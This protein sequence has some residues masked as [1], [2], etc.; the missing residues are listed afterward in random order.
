MFTNDHF[1]F[2]HATPSLN[3]LTTLSSKWDHIF[4]LWIVKCRSQWQVLL[5]T[6]LKFLM[7]SP[8]PC[9]NGVEIITSKTKG[10]HAQK[11]KEYKVERNRAKEWL[12]NEIFFCMY[13]D[14]LL[15]WN[16]L[17]LCWASTVWVYLILIFT[18]QPSV[19]KAYE[20]DF[21]GHVNSV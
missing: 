3:F 15:W 8:V 16:K 12:L 9:Q 13:T 14:I 11:M 21:C 20:C 7:F 4:N 1:L 5:N 10:A 19:N 6:P 17:V 2:S 18:H